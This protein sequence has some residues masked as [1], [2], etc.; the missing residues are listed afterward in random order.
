ML[1]WRPVMVERTAGDFP[2]LAFQGLAAVPSF[3]HAVTTR[4]TDGSAAAPSA[5]RSPEPDEEF[6]AALGIPARKLIL[7]EQEHADAVLAVEAGRPACGPGHPRADAVILTSPGWYGAIR[8]ADCLSVVIVD[9]RRRVLG[10]AHAGWRGTSRRVTAKA[11]ARLLRLT[12]AA[13]EDLH[14][15]FGPCI[16]SCCYEVGE[17]VRVAFR[18]RRHETEKIFEG[19]RLDLIRANRL[20]LE[21]LGVTRILDSG[22]CT[23]CRNDRFYSY[24]REKTARRMWTVAGFRLDEAQNLPTLA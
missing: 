20:Q 14:A 22:L 4:A 6:L 19:G 17:E 15:A 5:A 10:L 16:R 11:A 8:T 21:R 13:P 23:S 1:P 18:E 7:L 9:P 3:V 12:G 24:R 2:Y